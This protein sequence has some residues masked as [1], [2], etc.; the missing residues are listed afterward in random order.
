ME[1]E[2][3]KDEKKRLE[4]VAER[5]RKLRPR[6]VVHLMDQDSDDDI[7]NTPPQ[8]TKTK[9]RKVTQEP[10][11]ML[12]SVNQTEVSGESEDSFDENKARSELA[13]SSSDE[14]YLDS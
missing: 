9:T 2:G 7:N 14:D 5:Q 6:M 4:R 13:F 11:S 12:R 1:R 10:S 8:R 3:E